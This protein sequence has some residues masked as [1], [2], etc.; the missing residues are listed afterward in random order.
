MKKCVAANE[1]VVINKQSK[2]LINMKRLTR[3]DGF[4]KSLEGKG[5]ITAEMQSMVFSPDF[6]M[7]GGDNVGTAKKNCSNGGNG[8]NGVN[9]YCTN[10]DV[11]SDDAI[12]GSC[13]NTNLLSPACK[14]VETNPVKECGTGNIGKNLSIMSCGG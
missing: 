14:Q 1:F 6:G 4:L 8:C 12:N 3:I 10:I 9:G 5:V 11:C 13:K 2:L 7:L